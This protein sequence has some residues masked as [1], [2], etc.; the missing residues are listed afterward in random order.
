VNTLQMSTKS[1]FKSLAI[2]FG[3]HFR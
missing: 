1:K 3:S 2:Q